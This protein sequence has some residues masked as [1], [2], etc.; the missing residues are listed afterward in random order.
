MSYNPSEPKT[1]PTSQNVL[2]FLDEFVESDQKRRDSLALIAMMERITGQPPV[3]RGPSIIGFGSY[4]TSTGDWPAVAFSPRKA[5]LT[6]YIVSSTE[7]YAEQ[8][9]EL[10]KVKTS[11][12][13]IYIKKLSDID[14][15]KL[16]ELIKLGYKDTLNS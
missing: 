13:C 2:Q 10:G 16:G 8:I 11:K 12:A 7:L 5:A 1:K 6:L 15:D 3:M 9:A 4:A 14:T